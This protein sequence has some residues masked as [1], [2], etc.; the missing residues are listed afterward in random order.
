VFWPV[1]NAG[2]HDGLATP[3]QPLRTRESLHLVALDI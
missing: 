1:I 3:Q 2:G